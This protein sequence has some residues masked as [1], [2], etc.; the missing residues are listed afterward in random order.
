MN[1]NDWLDHAQMRLA[2][3]S[4]K[5]DTL[6]QE[7]LPLALIMV[8]TVLDLHEAVPVY[9]LRDEFGGFATNDDGEQILI[10][11]LCREC[12]SDDAIENVEDGEWHEGWEPEVS[13]PCPTIRAIE[14][15]L[16]EY[17]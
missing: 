11:T 14:N 6:N 15:T 8:R 16:K 5:Y 12:S 1:I 2:N 4:I 13:H 17:T 10:A 3:R 9:Q 7:D